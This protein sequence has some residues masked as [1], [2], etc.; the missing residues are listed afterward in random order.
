[1]ASR[2]RSQYE[3]PAAK[4]TSSCHGT[5]RMTT[6]TVQD[7][8]T[9]SVCKEPQRWSSR[10]HPYPRFPGDRK[11]AHRHDTCHHRQVL[12]SLAC[13]SQEKSYRKQPRKHRAWNGAQTRY[14]MV[15]A[16]QW[17]PKN[18]TNAITR[19]REITVHRKRHANFFKPCPG[20]VIHKR[21]TKAWE[22]STT[23]H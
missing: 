17:K 11:A 10:A 7:V 3:A 21:Y 20:T 13:R 8:A 15:H 14:Y 1:M 22:P 23:R 6:Y 16:T 2:L 4:K 12:K 18:S 19:W 5:K 9:S